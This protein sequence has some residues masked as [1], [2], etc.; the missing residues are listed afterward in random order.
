[1]P[2]L[3]VNH[4]H[5]EVSSVR[6]NYFTLRSKIKERPCRF[7]SESGSCASGCRNETLA[8]GGLLVNCSFL[9]LSEVPEN[10]PLNTEQLLLA[11][12]DIK[13]IG[14]GAFRELNASLKYLDLADNHITDID[15]EAFQ[16]LHQLD[17][18]LLERNGP[19]NVFPV[20]VFDELTELTTL[21]LHEYHEVNSTASSRDMSRVL[22]NLTNLKR[23]SFTTTLYKPSFEY[24]SA[25]AH[26]EEFY[27]Y[28]HNYRT[29]YNYIYFTNETFSLFSA[30]PIKL[31]LVRGIIHNLEPLTF[32]PFAKLDVLDLSYGYFANTSQVSK[33]WFG[34]RYTNISKLV[35]VSIFDGLLAMDELLFVGLEHTRLKRLY[36]DCNYLTFAGQVKWYN[37]YL[38]HLEYLS[39]ENN[40]LTGGNILTLMDSFS[41]LKF[42][43]INNQVNLYPGNEAISQATCYDSSLPGVY[44]YADDCL[45]LNQIIPPSTEPLLVRPPNCLEELLMESANPLFS[46]GGVAIDITP[47]I[48]HINLARNGL[49]EMHFRRVATSRMVPRR[50]IALYLSKNVFSMSRG[51]FSS[52]CSMCHQAA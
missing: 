22:G 30:T 50:K 13:R 39:L 6:C 26:L 45:T 27:V 15:K 40:W 31:L 37:K 18:L 8:S 21:D 46:S 51:K 9:G 24:L 28:A 19:S 10:L 44:K 36:L 17:T 14:R 52:A 2:W 7:L 5:L 3:K 43:S 49:S 32:S 42:L 38:P 1:M 41:A 12:N 29:H 16:A 20:E 48:Q 34:L 47:N 11:H 33:A 23:F 4:A 25:Q 35:L